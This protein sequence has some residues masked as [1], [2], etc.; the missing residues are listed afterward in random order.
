VSALG[1]GPGDE[2]LCPAF[3]II[4]CA[5][6]IVLSG[7]TPVL[8]DVDP[9]TWCIDV[10]RA[11]ARTGPRTRAVLGVHA[12]GHPYDHS[13][14]TELARRRELV[15]VEDAA[16][17]HGARVRTPGGALPCGGLGDVSVFSFYANKAVTTGEGGMVLSRSSGVAA[18]VRALA[19]LFM[20]KDRRFV[21]EELGHNYRL[22]SLQAALGISQLARL[23]ETIERK[24]FIARCYRERLARIEEVELQGVS[25][26]A[27]PTFWMNAIVLSDSVP[28]DAEALGRV[29][30]RRGVETRPL[31]TG[32]H[33][34]PALI[35]RGFFDGEHHPVTERLSRR[36]L[37]L[38]SGL[39]LDEAA[40][41]DVVRELRAALSELGDERAS[42]PVAIPGR[43]DGERRDAEASSTVFGDAFAEGY[44]ALYA[45][46]DYAV[47]VTRL[48]DC[49]ARHSASPVRRVLDVGCGT[50]RHVAELAARGYDVVGVDRSAEML[51]IAKRRSPA[52][53]FVEADMCE[54]ELGET[55]DAVVVLF[56]ALSYNT[57][58]SAIQRTLS[59]LR[60]H[61]SAGGLLVADV[62]FGAAAPTARPV[63][64]RRTASVARVQW[65][66]T[67]VLQRDPLRQRVDIAYELGRR[68]PDGYSVAREMHRMHYFMPFELEFALELSGFRL[69]HLSRETDLDKAPN[70]R[71]LTALFVARAR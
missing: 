21:H 35:S 3:T 1:L 23:A 16:Q 10:A 13:A 9:S 33:E 45:D 44:D 43:S 64:T 68:S 67:G 51:A 40:I 59:A 19:N 34:Q 39:L 28:A 70:E 53:R 58:P 17:A 50:G 15:I 32:L 55:F 2:V 41:D 25:G 71:D 27:E 38:P 69:V 29:L 11:E 54:V 6:A 14:L 5:R 47:E 8:V 56:A 37:Y 26:D 65:E 46:K 36:G 42:V 57:T 48:E 63:V 49:F 30:A 18:R 12:F 52:G 22:S 62:W 4:S 66:R 20:G 31:F 24:R 61:V 60:R 7:A